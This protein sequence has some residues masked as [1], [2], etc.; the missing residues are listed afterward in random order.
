M[1]RHTGARLID[2]TKVQLHP[3]GFI[4]PKKPTDR[5]KFLAAEALRG[6]G[7]IMVN[8]KGVRFANELGRRDEVT[9]LILDH[10]DI[11]EKAKAHTAYLLMNDKA[12]DRFGWPAFNF[13]WKIKGF[14]TVRMT[15]PCP[16][17]ELE[18][19]ILFAFSKFRRRVH[20]IFYTLT[21]LCS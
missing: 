15:P 1:F 9:K 19:Q 7:G 2:M 13:Y 10:C 6:A 20:G 5:T 18:R 21:I 12:I 14:F 8:Q 11:D 16:V 4:D 3:T 17:R